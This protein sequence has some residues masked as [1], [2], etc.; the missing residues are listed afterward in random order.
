MGGERPMEEERVPAEGIA[1]PG[2][3]RAADGFSLA[4]SASVEGL[5][6]ALG[7]RYGLRRLSAS[8]QRLSVLD[9][10]FGRLHAAGLWLLTQEQ[11]GLL[12]LVLVPRDGS[13]AES[14][15]IEKAPDFA[16][17]L[18][19]GPVRSRLQSLAKRCRLLPLARID[20][21]SGAWAV[22]DDRDEPVARLIVEAAVVRDPSSPARPIALPTTLRVVRMGERRR[23][24]AR[25]LDWLAGRPE[26]E[27]VE[28]DLFERALRALGRRP[29]ARCA[30][31]VGRLDPEAPAGLAFVQL[32]RGLLETM[33]ANEHGIVADLDTE[34]L[35]DFRVA[36]R[37]S[38][39]LH[40]IFRGEIRGSAFEELLPGFQW[41]GRITGPTRDLDVHLIEIL[42]RGSHAPEDA[43]LEALVQLLQERRRQE[44]AKLVEALG[45]EPYAD[46]MA[47]AR[48]LLEGRDGPALERVAAA[49]PPLRGWAS[50]RIA[51]AH[52][53]LSKRGR[54]IDRSSADAKLHKVRIDAKRLRYLLEFFQ[55]L[56]RPGPIRKLVGELERL[57]DN[58]GR[59]NDAC[60]QR[61]TLRELAH[62]LDRLGRGGPDTQLAI[63][64]LLERAERRRRVE[65]GRFEARFARFE[66]PGTRRRFR[67]LFG[68]ETEAARQG[69]CSA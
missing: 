46:F 26:L 65:R 50:D 52:R 47:R 27:R 21:E 66:G 3:A 54:R 53:R 56:Y 69:E 51:R 24:H 45:S 25:L 18:S 6:E 30:S 23:R 1:S 59:F 16:T 31:S 60:V 68:S 11:S 44:W 62:D 10:D 36:L 9:T 14:M 63:G 67:R 61:E 19:E 38:R 57:Q 35:H 40:R 34:H 41:L 49:G 42:E 29:E 28:L 22:L 7:A 64:R 13:P 17:D 5:L 39:V 4:R 32:Q 15:R 12:W 20:V 43:S 37:R 33:R 58:L 2:S 55:E 48:A 8:E